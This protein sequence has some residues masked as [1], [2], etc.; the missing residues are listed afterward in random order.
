MQSV[1]ARA[2]LLLPR[3]A[4]LLLAPATALVSLSLLSCR[5][6]NVCVTPRKEGAPLANAWFYPHPRTQEVWSHWTIG[7]VLGSVIPASLISHEYRA[8]EGMHVQ[9]AFPNQKTPSTLPRSRSARCVLE[10]ASV[11]PDVLVVWVGGCVCRCVRGLPVVHAL[12]VQEQPGR[13][14]E[15][16]VV[17]L[18]V[19]SYF[20][21]L[22]LS[23]SLGGCTL[24]SRCLDLPRNKTKTKQTKTSSPRN[25]RRVLLRRRRKKKKRYL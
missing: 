22:S 21:F 24:C 9:P 5:L 20:L 14:V 19:V 4:L 2:K 18:F 25:E 16:R 17:G 15:P 1:S 12:C 11:G 6:G 23:L 3:T 10:A 8:A 7:D 13:L